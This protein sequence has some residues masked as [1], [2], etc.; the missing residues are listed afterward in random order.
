VNNDGDFIIGDNR[1]DCRLALRLSWNPVKDRDCDDVST[2]TFIYLTPQN[3][4]GL[5]IMY[6]VLT[7]RPDNDVLTFIHGYRY[8]LFLPESF[9]ID[10]VGLGWPDGRR[11]QG[12]M[13]RQTFW[14]VGDPNAVTP[15]PLESDQ[16][17][18]VIVTTNFK[19]DTVLLDSPL[20]P[21]LKF[22]FSEPVE[23]YLKYIQ[24]TIDIVATPNI[25][26][27]GYS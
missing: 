27:V 4:T 9:V 19:N 8:C 23:Y 7:F 16:I 15:P 12:Y 21:L 3:Y 10:N 11:G 24:G 25:S 14:V 20:N 18:P 2:D 6:N 17:F 26:F 22:Q 1:Y 5:K 13:H